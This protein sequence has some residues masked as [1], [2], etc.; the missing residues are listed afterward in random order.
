[1]S[2][3]NNSTFEKNALLLQDEQIKK[4][5]ETEVDCKVIF[6]ID[7]LKQKYGNSSLISSYEEDYTRNNIEVNKLRQLN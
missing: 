7:K 2:Q 1:M 5:I 6:Y 3:T 4:N